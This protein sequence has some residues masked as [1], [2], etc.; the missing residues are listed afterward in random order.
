[1]AD[2]AKW[3]FTKIWLFLSAYLIR[4]FERKV[5]PLFTKVHV[6]SEVDTNYLKALNPE[7]DL[8]TIPIAIDGAFLDKAESSHDEDV[9]NESR[10]TIICTGNLKSPGIAKGVQL[11]ME[12]A[13]P[14]ILKERPDAQLLVLAQNASP[15]F[16]LKFKQR[17][18][19]ELYEWVEDYRKFIS[20]ADVLIVPDL[21]GTGIKTRVAQAMGIGLAVV[22]TETAFE[23]IPF[24][25]GEHGMKYATMTECAASVIRLINDKSL[26]KV[27]GESAHR[28]ALKQFSLNIVGP[29]YEKLYQEAIAKFHSH[30]AI[31]KHL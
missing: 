10:P 14:L 15:V 24:V 1:M 6:V 17:Q 11:F 18:N 25:H 20:Q 23:G 2:Q 27:I 19:V 26:R 22:G 16:C 5:F 29:Q 31:C 3:S 8:V 7:I 21:D 12:F 28:L 9:T 4:R 30:L 13:W